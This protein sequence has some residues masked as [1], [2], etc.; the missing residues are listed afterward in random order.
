MNNSDNKIRLNKFLSNAGVASRRK[1]DELILKG[2]IKV[3][4]KIIN[5]LGAKINPIDEVLVNGK[6]VTIKNFQY[7]L[8]NKPKGYITTKSDPHER[9][10]IYDLINDNSLKKLNPVGR[11]DRNSSGLLLLT[12]DGDLAHK[13][14]HPSHG[15]KKIYKVELDKNL[16]DE[17]FNKLIK[18]VTLEDGLSLFD[19]ISFVGSSKNILGIELH[20]GKN[21][22]IRRT[23]EA[24]GCKVLKLDRVMYAGLTK[25]N[26]SRGKWRN[27]SD[28]EVNILNKTIRK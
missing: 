16:S 1:A 26:L 11:L 3:N 15:I 9:K 28:K 10:T 14:S 7:I 22:I 6:Q 13:L 18:G 4:G 2:K 24:I 20:S 8:L 21:R 19:K 27:L 5:T 25:K 12:N 23:F 17:D